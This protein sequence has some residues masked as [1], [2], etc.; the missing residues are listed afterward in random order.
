MCARGTRRSAPART[1]RCVAQPTHRNATSPVFTCAPL[2][3]TARVNATRQRP[4]P[5][6][7]ARTPHTNNVTNHRIEK[8]IDQCIN[9]SLH[10]SVYTQ[11]ASQDSHAHVRGIASSHPLWTPS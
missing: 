3:V 2:P 9:P 10:Q 11:A 7:H 1:G 8:P 6:T 4:I 5:Q